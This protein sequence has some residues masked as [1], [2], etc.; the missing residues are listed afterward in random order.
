MSSKKLKNT[1]KIGI[2]TNIEISNDDKNQIFKFLN[3]FDLYTNVWYLC[4]HYKSS[5]V[6]DTL[7]KIKN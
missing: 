6:M 2:S 1:V 5:S 3:I 7:K 4:V